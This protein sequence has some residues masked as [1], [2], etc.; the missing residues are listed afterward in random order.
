MELQTN[1]VNSLKRLKELN[2]H[3]LEIAKKYHKKINV[4]NKM[5][6]SKDCSYHLYW[7]RVKNRNDFMKKMTK[8]GIETGVHYKPVHK[9]SYYKN[10]RKLPVC[11]RIQG[12]IISLPIHANLSDEQVERVIQTV[13]TI[14]N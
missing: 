10:K 2:K 8:E 4:E 14:I 12:E 6:L 13:N 11:E 5:P 3:R 9:M 1:F 7:I